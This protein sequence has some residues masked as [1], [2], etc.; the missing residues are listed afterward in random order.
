MKSKNH[1]AD[2]VNWET[3]YTEQN[4]G[5]DIGY[6][7]TPLAEFID[8]WKDT[9]AKVL[10][11]GCGRGYELEYLWKRGFKNAYGLDIAPSAKAEFLKRVPDFPA[12]QFLLDS[13]WDLDSTFDLILEQTFYCA[14][15]VENRDQYIEK[16]SNLL[17]PNGTLAGLLFDFP[18][19]EVGPPFGG[20]L[21]EYKERM[22]RLGTLQIEP[23]HNSIK[24]RM[25]KEFFFIAQK[26]D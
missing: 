13:F 7:S 24:P 26:G 22:G 23:C 4:T 2:P 3:R 9:E 12:D 20:S 19:T 17:T 16:M 18:L 21:E 8:Q 25:G 5:W 11:P 14:I 10:I 15:P 1:T 6:P